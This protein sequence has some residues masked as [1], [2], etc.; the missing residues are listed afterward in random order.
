MS[1]QRRGR[2]GVRQLSLGLDRAT[3]RVLHAADLHLDSPLIGL[4]RYEG[5]PVEEIRSATRRAF[6]QL[7]EL[8]VLERVG[9]V[10]IAGDVYDGDWKDYHTGLFFA[11]R[12]Q[13]L[14]DEGI[15]VAMIRGNHDAAS[16]ISRALRLPENVHE[17]PVDQAATVVFDRLGIAVHGQGYR[18]SAVTED[19]VPGYPP[20]VKG[21]FNIGLLHTCLEGRLGHATYA[22]TSTGAMIAKG[23]DYWALGHVHSREIVSTEPWI[24][25]PGN[26]QGRQ[27]REHGPKGATLLVLEDGRLV[28]VEHRSLDVVRWQTI[29]V[30]VSSRATVD[31]VLERVEEALLRASEAAEERL[32]AARIRL[33]GM[34]AAHPKLAAEAQR[35][36]EEIRLLGTGVAS[37]RVWIERVELATRSAIDLELLARSGGP[38]AGLITALRELPEDELAISALAAELAELKK[39]IPERLL[40]EEGQSDLLVRRLVPELEQLLVP[41]LLEAES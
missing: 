29:E 7:V 11:S 39:K 32:L 2:R 5:A 20:A 9:L 34:S 38:L 35:V 21:L 12:M 19:L 3:V 18:D 41:L 4:A 15:E 23:Y 30:D 37:G 22:P 28:A 1:T 27:V 40:G 36:Q 6:D 26:L 33:T 8:A 25:F 10:L 14:K 16:R 24:V 17:F 31:Q 13:R